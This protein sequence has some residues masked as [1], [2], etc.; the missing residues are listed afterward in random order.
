MN[1]LAAPFRT[2]LHIK[3]LS[4]ELDED[5][6]LVLA[7]LGIAPDEVIEKVQSAPLG[8]PISIKVGDQLFSLRR[9]TCAH[10]FVEDA[11]K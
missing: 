5:S 7:Q 10:I 11:W 6:G 1:L 8:D 9:D 3:S 4:A 2:P